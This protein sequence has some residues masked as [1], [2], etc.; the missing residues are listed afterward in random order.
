MA[1]TITNV[2][3][4]NNSSDLIMITE[5][6]LYIVFVLI[7]SPFITI[8]RLEKRFDRPNMLYSLLFLKALNTGQC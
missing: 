7:L 6:G 1:S 3:R 2:L 8:M 5:L 4:A